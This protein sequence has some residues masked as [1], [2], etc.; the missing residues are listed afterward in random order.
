MVSLILLDGSSQG[1]KFN[2]RGLCFFITS[3]N[4]LF[5]LIYYCCSQGN[6]GCSHNLA[7][8]VNKEIL[9]FALSCINKNCVKL[10]YVAHLK[11]F[12]LFAEMIV[13]TVGCV[14]SIRTLTQLKWLKVIWKVIPPKT[15][16]LVR[17]MKIQFRKVKQLNEHNL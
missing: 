6:Y 13:I 11:C 16:I 12:L 8:S 7:V 14:L 2:L 1:K 9:V 4:H 5:D 10:V 3:F 15:A 17:I